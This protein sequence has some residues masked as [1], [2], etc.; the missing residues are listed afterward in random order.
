MLFFIIL[1][2]DYSTWA[3]LISAFNQLLYQLPLPTPNIHH[4]PSTLCQHLLASFLNKIFDILQALSSSFLLLF[5]LKFQYSFI[6]PIFFHCIASI[7]LQSFLT[8]KIS[9]HIVLS[10]LAFCWFKDSISIDPIPTLVKSKGDNDRFNCQLN[11]L[12]LIV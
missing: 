1:R 12:R 4:N 6:W 10:F 5:L 2:G 8:T 9:S 11:P 3:Q 7:I